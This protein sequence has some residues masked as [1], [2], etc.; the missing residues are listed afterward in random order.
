MSV[1]VWAVAMAKDEG[2]IIDHTMNHFAANGVD[3]II[4]ADNMSNDNT[5]EKMEEAKNN[6]GLKLTNVQVIL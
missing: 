5:R 6:I 4:I 2:D 1:N 3:G